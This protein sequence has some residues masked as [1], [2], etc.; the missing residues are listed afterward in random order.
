MSVN[1]WFSDE[2]F[3]SVKEYSKEL[4]EKRKQAQNFVLNLILRDGESAVVRFLTQE[5]ITFRE[6]YIPGAKGQKFYTCLEGTRDEDGNRV[7]CPFCSAG[8][9]PSFRGAFLV[10]D[11]SEDTWKSNGE[12]HSAQNQI[13]IFKQGIKVM[14]VLDSLSEKRDLTEWDIEISRTGSG[15]DTQYNFIPE[16]KFEL[17]EE[18]EK[19]IEEFKGDKTF[20]DII[21]NEVEPVSMNKALSIMGGGKPDNQPKQYEDGE[22]ESIRF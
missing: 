7:Q 19:K 1:N 3:D 17:S 18:V 22:N 11:R 2:G 6:H 14:K 13:K 4:D 20:K 8:N 16:E 9:K 12:E 10:V 15:T 5:P 21:I